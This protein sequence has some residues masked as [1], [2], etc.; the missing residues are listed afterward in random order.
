[1]KIYKVVKVGT[2][3]DKN[4]IFAFE[5]ELNIEAQEGWELHSL[6]PQLDEGSVFNNIAIFVRDSNDE[7]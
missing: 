5:S 2:L 1:M 7:E 6:V 4:P 3:H